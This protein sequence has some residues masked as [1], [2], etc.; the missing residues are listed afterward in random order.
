MPGKGV[1]A[2]GPG[3]KRGCDAAGMKNRERCAIRYIASGM[4]EDE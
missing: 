4:H 2:P 1:E 3:P